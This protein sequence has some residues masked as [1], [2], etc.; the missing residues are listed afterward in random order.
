MTHVLLS[1]T[2][3]FLTYTGIETY[4]LFSKGIDLPG[5]AC[6]PLLETEDGKRVLRQ[7]YSR[8]LLIS[9]SLGLGAI[10][11]A[12]TWAAHRGR[13][14]PLGYSP[15]QLHSLNIEGVALIEEIRDA[16]LVENNNDR[17]NV[18]CLLS[19]NVGPFGDAY[20]PG[21]QLSEAEADEFHAEQM[22]AFSQ[23]NADLV[24]AYT[25]TY[26]AEATGIVRAAQALDIP[27]VISF[28][29]DTNGHLPSGVSLY[30]AVAEVDEKTGSYAS[31]FMVN[32]A[33]PDH[34]GDV[35]RDLPCPR[36]LKGI[37]A[38]ASRCSHAELDNAEVLDSGDPN[39]LAQQLSAFKLANDSIT[40]LGGCC[41]T[42]MSHLIDIGMRM[43]SIDQSR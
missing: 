38:N 21:N 34:F 17:W 18:P 36:R 27:V 28:T 42:D 23:T 10:L 8:Q 29:V 11:E 2:R 19:A 1:Q 35:L 3:S 13:G 15:Q 12:P 20:A 4:L 40:V 37:V 39:E 32:C 30:D 43:R 41:G 9:S 25:L 6:F 24:T 5:F 7:I 14:G 31:Y 22:V 16:Y 26:P 33:H